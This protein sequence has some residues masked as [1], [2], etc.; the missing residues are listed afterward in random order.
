LPDARGAA[1]LAHLLAAAGSLPAGLLEEGVDPPERASAPRGARSADRRF[2]N[3]GRRRR[4]EALGPGRPEVAAIP[5]TATLRRSN[6]TNGRRKPPGRVTPS[7]Y[8][9]APLRLIVAPGISL[10]LVSA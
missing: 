4:G 7:T 8:P 10:A 5:G 2:T 6:G 3:V 1:H 9:V